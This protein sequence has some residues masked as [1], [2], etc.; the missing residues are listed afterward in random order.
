[1]RANYNFLFLFGISRRRLMWFLTFIDFIII[2]CDENE[3][4]SIKILSMTRDDIIGDACSLSPIRN[5]DRIIYCQ[6]SVASINRMSKCNELLQYIHTGFGCW[7][8]GLCVSESVSVG[9]T[10]DT[11]VYATFY[12]EMLGCWIS[13]GEDFL[14][15]LLSPVYHN[16]FFCNDEFNVKFGMN[17]IRIEY[18][19]KR[20]FMPNRLRLLLMSPFP[21][22]NVCVCVCRSR[23]DRW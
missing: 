13:Q 18:I 12:S 15:L 4:N 22:S 6:I 9:K 3:F 23:V 14:L 20:E 8:F 1:M 19:C 11:I 10:H 17:L 16:F 21:Y 7:Q 5:D 2:L